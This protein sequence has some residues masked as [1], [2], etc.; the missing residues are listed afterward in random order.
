MRTPVRRFVLAAIVAC[1]VVPASAHASFVGNIDW[2][3][4]SPAAGVQVLWGTFSDP[5][6][7]PLWTVT[8]E[9]PTRSPFDGTP[10]LAE[11]GSAGWA[12]QTVSALSAKGFTAREDT[13]RWPR[14]VDDPRGVIGA[15]V[16][17]GEFP[18]QAAAVGEAS[19]LT[20]AG[21]SPLVEWE[22]FDPKP[23]PDA[24]LLHAAIIDLHR[25]GGHVIATHGDAIAS[26]R[27]V[28]A[29]A[30]QLG[31]LVAVN[32][33]FFTINAALP[34]V[35]GVP[36]GLG[37][38][39]G[40]LE[41]LSNG[42][43]ADLVLDGRRTPQV[44]NL[45]ATAQLR[46][47]HSTINVL[48]INR[49]PGSTEDCGV[50]SFSPTSSPRQGTVCTATD[51]LVLFT[52]EFDAPL[53]TVAG[54]VQ[55]T[56]NPQGRVLALGAP[57]GSLP[58]GDSAVQA[59]GSDAAWLQAHAQ[60]GTRLVITEQLHKRNGAQFQVDR[61]TDIVSAAPVLLRDGRLAIDAV[62]EGVLDPR[63]LNNYSFSADRH[64]RTIAGIDRRGRLLLVTAD[65]IPG[66]SEGLTLT[67]EAHLMR[68]LGAVDAMNLDGGG[69]TSFVVD[70]T[71]IN[72]TSDAAG[73]RAVGDS[74]E[75]VP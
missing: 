75:V 60:P 56:L 46:A 45:R 2:T 57:A 40:Q 8:I 42:T 17:V 12:D 64:A 36:T 59:I 71:T 72:R 68:S 69:S 19:S 49:Q 15:R 58:P 5:T 30:Q 20:A 13:L 22:G 66:V 48:G 51:D 74:I 34:A 16:R 53:P 25:F 43:R 52:P 6:A 7:R 67:E 11:A 35:G 54:T 28:A 27:T 29:Q 23:G 65:G 10:E 44:E 41:S 26:R 24:E 21:F 70:G 47:A 38:Y 32:A 61:Q 39:D 9:A 1:A 3:S 37:V 55:A 31:A 18:T 62:T 4:S 14:Y 73:P 33:G 50:P 63:D